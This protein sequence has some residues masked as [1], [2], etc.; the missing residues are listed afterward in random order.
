MDFGLTT[1][2]DIRLVLLHSSE[3]Q[4]SQITC[5]LLSISSNGQN[6]P[7]F[8]AI[9]YLDIDITPSKLI[10]LDGKDVLVTV[11]LESALRHL[12]LPSEGRYLWVQSLCL[13]EP[14]PSDPRVV[15]KDNA[16]IHIAAREMIIWLGEDTP[17][18]RV[19]FSA[20]ALLPTLARPRTSVE[21]SEQLEKKLRIPY[22]ENALSSSQP[23][24]NLS[25][26]HWE[27]IEAIIQ[28]GIP[29]KASFRCGRYGMSWD[30][31]S[32]FVYTLRF[33]LPR[34]RY[35]YPVWFDQILLQIPG[36][37]PESF[38]EVFYE[39]FEGDR[40]S[41]QQDEITWGYGP[42][43]AHP[44]DVLYWLTNKSEAS[45]AGRV[46]T[47][48]SVR[49][50]NRYK[51]RCFWKM[52][53]DSKERH[54]AAAKKSSSSPSSD[55]NGLPSADLSD[56][57][58]LFGG[59]SDSDRALDAWLGVLIAAGAF[60]KYE[61]SQAI[62]KAARSNQKT[63]TS[64]QEAA[65]SAEGESA[66]YVYEPLKPN[67]QQIRV[68]LLHPS[69]D[70]SAD[71]YCDVFVLDLD[72]WQKQG[73][74]SYP[75]MALSY[76]WGNPNPPRSIFLGGKRRNVGPSLFEALKELR[77]PS[78]PALLWVDALCID[79]SNASEKNHQVGMM[80][81]IY[82]RAGC[83]LI[84]VDDKETMPPRYDLVGMEDP[85]SF[86]MDNLSTFEM[87]L[88]S[89]L[90]EV[91]SNDKEQPVLKKFQELSRGW[92]NL[93]S[94]K[95]LFTR[96]YWTRVWTMQ[97]ALLGRNM[98]LCH[99]GY[100][101]YFQTLLFLFLREWKRTIPQ[102]SYNYGEYN[103]DSPL[104]RFLTLRWEIQ[105]GRMPSPLAGM[106]LS[107]E[108][109][110]TMKQDYV[111]G[112]LGII[113]TGASLGKPDYDRDLFYISRDIFQHIL[114]TEGN[115]DVLTACE[116]RNHYH[117]DPIGKIRDQTTWPSWL[118][119]W[120]IKPVD[121]RMAR[122][123]LLA[124]ETSRRKRFKAAGNTRPVF[125]LLDEEMLLMVRGAIVDEI[126]CTASEE[127]SFRHVQ[128]WRLCSASRRSRNLYGKD[129][130]DLKNAFNQTISLGQ[131]ISYDI[132]GLEDKEAE[133]IDDDDDTS[134]GNGGDPKDLRYQATPLDDE[135]DPVVLP[136]DEGRVQVLNAFKTT[137]YIS[138]FFITK[139]G[140]IG[141]GPIT[142]AKG[143]PVVIFLGAK[144]PH[145]MR[146]VEGTDEYR[147]LGE[148]YVHGIMQGA[149]MQEL[150]NI[151]IQDFIIK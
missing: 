132:Y 114:D 98:L 31:F 37:I 128:E 15:I 51:N 42:M 56:S 130:T 58:Q 74:E 47:G 136:D 124:E 139:R 118:P 46:L 113:S 23:L 27:R 122:S 83:V 70:P 12:R 19:A 137:T 100:V 10:Q 112:V 143:D 17:L 40:T 126:E 6:P 146:K 66:T 49:L 116:V 85:T 16:D 26:W 96:S 8:D 119:N 60:H 138:R 81:P 92:M 57:A 48:L 18:S 59:L 63:T 78:V 39:E 141:R 145:V 50:C 30:I 44:Q 105:S 41:H 125:R 72:Y 7:P 21:K 123:V 3:E 67:C 109:S 11:I 94:Y 95:E 127:W 32:T 36:K 86:V 144:V 149:L 129:L 62:L 84:W 87:F 14:Y 55:S 120:S 82:N 147:I 29:A 134:D 33:T 52:K 65:D 69:R 135:I 103:D 97:E 131:P 68:L 38:R 111:F 151:E 91:G 110:A 77:D 13:G 34:L 117:T 88:F 140:Y 102:E 90:Y 53:R 64:D 54:H 93:H 75:Y 45:K 148:C 5:D 28:L 9:S 121:S 150:G 2:K 43:F 25:W 24:F 104:E 107:R 108:R 142:T 4:D 1:S 133:E 71:I 80:G 61:R 35:D 99:G 22:I 106:L 20:V 115:I 79:Q 101:V 76:V 89:P 73:V